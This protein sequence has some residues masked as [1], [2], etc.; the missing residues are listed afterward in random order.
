M[1]ARLAPF[2]RGLEDYDEDY[3]EESIG[4]L[5]TELREKDFEEG[6]SN[7][8]VEAMKAERE[9]ASGIG[10]VTKKIGIHKNRENR[11]EEEKAERDK[12]ER[13]AYLGAVECPICFLVRA[14][15]LTMRMA[16]AHAQ[17]YPSN[18]NTSRCCQQPICTE[19]FVQ[20][21]RG[22]ATLTHL[23]S[24]PACCPF[25]VETDFGVI[26]ERPNLPS[27]LTSSSA[28][29][30]EDAELSVGVGMAPKVQETMR[31]KSV[32][33]KSKEVVTIGASLFQHVTRPATDRR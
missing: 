11:V 22:E 31:R 8:V 13:R 33:H 19:C 6:V 16:K 21:K 17:N 9:P 2:Y 5:L 23:E 29:G 30:K 32:S 14:P 3:T 28:L 10:S 26:Y 18:I 7:S 25:C 15:N 27:P 1:E 24:E 4:K 12:R 20:I